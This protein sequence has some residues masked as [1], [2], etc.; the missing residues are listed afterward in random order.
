M[1]RE[2]IARTRD[3][4]DLMIRFMRIV[5]YRDP[6]VHEHEIYPKARGKFSAKV[7]QLFRSIFD[8]DVLL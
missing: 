6:R 5:N 4:T 8:K 3:A 7:P 2:A 1:K